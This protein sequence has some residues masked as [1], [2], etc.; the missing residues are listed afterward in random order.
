LKRKV[1]GTEEER[2]KTLHDVREATVENG[3]L[4]SRVQSLV[5]AFSPSISCSG[6]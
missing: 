3:R 4:V 6:E 5:R 2:L 1:D